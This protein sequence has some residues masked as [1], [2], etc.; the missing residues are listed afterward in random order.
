MRCTL[1]PIFL[2]RCPAMF[3]TLTYPPSTGTRR[4]EIH[5][6]FIGARMG[7]VWDRDENTAQKTPL[8][9]HNCRFHCK[10]IF[11]DSFH[12]WIH[13]HKNARMYHAQRSASDTV[14]L[15]NEFVWIREW[16]LMLYV[17]DL[18]SMPSGYFLCL[19]L[20]HPLPLLA[21]YLA[22]PVKKCFT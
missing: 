11:L 10:I 5:L 8:Q 19:V 13:S 3:H 16:G 7:G 12:N 1:P 14:E 20:V 9:S 22:P 18:F 17:M 21:I 4:A 6:P 2:R 15:V